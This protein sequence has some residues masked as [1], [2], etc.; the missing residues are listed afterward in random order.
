MSV[1]ENMCD[2]I[3][4]IF[5][6]KKV[7]DGTLASIQNQFGSD[8]LRVAVDGGS[9]S[10]E[11]L[12]GVEKVRNLGQVQE[13]RMTAACDPQEVLR[14]LVARTRVNSFSVV[15]PS[16]HDIF[17]R[18]AGPAAEEDKKEEAVRA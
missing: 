17:I 9:Q 10:L 16:L 7:L 4:M 15:Q 1:A 5:R 12:P 14:T 8:T 6:G 2:Y 3:F 13:L 18:I 11:G